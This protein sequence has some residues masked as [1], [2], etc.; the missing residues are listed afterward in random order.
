MINYYEVLN[1][2]FNS[3]IEEIKRNYKQLALKFHP[4]K[5]K[6]DSESFLRIQEAWDV[7]SD[8]TKRKQFDLEIELRT[9]H[10]LLYG[11]FKIAD[12][13]RDEDG[14]HFCLCRC[15]GAYILNEEDL[16]LIVLFSVLHIPCDNCSLT[17]KF[18][19]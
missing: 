2:T 3:T 14:N 15:G 10:P 18:E 13:A 4:D 16:K 6:A 7:L 9:S 1:C 8:E 19:C 12:L 17:A 11:S 5:N